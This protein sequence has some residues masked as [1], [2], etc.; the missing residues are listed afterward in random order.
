ML[1]WLPLVL[2]LA[3]LPAA[4]C[5]GGPSQPEG[6]IKVTLTEFKFDPSSIDAKSGKAV[7]FLVNSGSTSHDMV[8][9]DSSG[10]QLAK[11]ELVQAGNAAVFTVD[12]LAAGSYVIYCDVAGHRASGMEGQLK[13]S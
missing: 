5:G 11:S 2:V 4:A 9:T 7:F 6:S 1:R 10:K 12:N 8:I 13:V 3:L